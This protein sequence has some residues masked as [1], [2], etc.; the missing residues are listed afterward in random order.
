MRAFMSGRVPTATLLFLALP[1]AQAAAQSPFIPVEPGPSAGIEL[2]RPGYSARFDDEIG[3]LTGQVHLSAALPVSAGV[4]FIAEVPLAHF[5]PGFD[6]YEGSTSRVGNP[7]LGV[8]F[9]DASRLGGRFG[10][11]LPLATAGDG[12][13]AA[14]LETGAFADYDRIEA[15]MPRVLT[16][17]LAGQMGRTA[18]S[19]LMGRIVLG[20]D[21]MVNTDGGDPELFASYGAQTGYARYGTAAIIAFTGRAIVTEGEL[22]L[23]ERTIHQVTLSGAHRFGRVMP[24]LWLRMPVDGELSELI[25]YALGFSMRVG[26]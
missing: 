19:G 5:D 1:A 17:G 7:Y 4:R 20:G 11:R 22:S 3:G 8:R 14:P 9:G 23:A 25:D 21:M 18:V 24:T 2:V 6:G 13:D 15:F 12:G 10:V 26:I 16:V